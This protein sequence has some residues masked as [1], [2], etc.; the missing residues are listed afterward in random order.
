MFEGGWANNPNDPG[1]AIMKSITQRT[2][3]QYL[4]R[5]ASQEATA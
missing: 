4:G 2:Y 1:G 3:S 5:Q